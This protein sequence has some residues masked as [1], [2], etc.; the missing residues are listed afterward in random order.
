LRVYRIP[1]R[2]RDETMADFQTG[3]TYNRRA[4]IHARFHGQMQGGISTPAKHSVIFA[5]TGTSGRRHGYSDELSIT[6]EVRLEN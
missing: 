5:F 1:E 3:V 4:D 6:P 2:E